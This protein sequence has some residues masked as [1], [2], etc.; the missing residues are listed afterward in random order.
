MSRVCGD[1]AD[2][3]YA[4]DCGVEKAEHGSA[5]LLPSDYNNPGDPWKISGA[6]GG[7]SDSPLCNLSV[8]VDF[9]PVWGCLLI[10]LLWL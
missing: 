9:F 6:A 4:C 10:D 7:V 8:S 5:S 1:C 2:S 3:Y